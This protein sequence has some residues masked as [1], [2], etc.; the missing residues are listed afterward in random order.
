MNDP[1]DSLSNDEFEFIETFDEDSEDRDDQWSMQQSIKI[2]PISIQ[3]P[4]TIQSE[5][6]PSPVG[7]RAPESL[8]DPDRTPEASL[9]ESPLLTQSLK[10]NTPMHT[11]IASLV[12]PMS[13]AV[14]TLQ[15]MS[16]VSESECSNNSSLVN[17]A[18]VESTEVALRTSL[19]LVGELKAQLN[20]QASTL[21]KL[22]SSSNLEENRKLSDQMKDEFQLKMQE[23]AA[24]VEKIIAEKDLAIEQLKVQLAQSQQVA[25]LWKQGAEKNSNASY[26]DSKTVIDRLL[27]ENSRLR[28]QV[29]EEVARRLQETDHRKMLAE[30]LKEARGG[31]TFDP[32]A[33]MIARQLADRTEYSLR[34]EQELVTVRQELE[35]AK[36]ALK[37]ATEESSNKDQIV[38]A[39]HEDQQ[40]STRMLVSNEQLINSLKQKCRQLGVLEDFA[41]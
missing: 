12:D 29:D 38:S 22:N 36:N 39:L 10:E 34:L 41:S 35:E 32:P 19:L 5:R 24:S 20:A 4:N 17:V 3:M 40:E 6:A 11:P 9:I 28:N 25:Q 23:S 18:D 16:L 15:N 7:T 2:E 30:Q 21:Q 8:S 26:S 1:L 37:K 14:P 13:T 31:S 27:E 33:T